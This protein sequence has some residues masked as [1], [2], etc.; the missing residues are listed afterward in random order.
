M[1]NRREFFISRRVRLGSQLCVVVFAIAFVWHA[2]QGVM[3]Y[4]GRGIGAPWWLRVLAAVAHGLIASY[5]AW[6]LAHSARPVVCIGEREVEWGSPFYFSGRRHR[7]RFDEI[8]SIGWKS[9]RRIRLD[10]GPNG[11]VAMR[12]AELDK[13][14][15]QAVYDAVA[16]RIAGAAG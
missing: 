2:A 6:G 3:E 11:E 8:R 1:R 5:F 10:L 9:P 7:A 13:R 16:R 14:E 15:R 12:V 4:L